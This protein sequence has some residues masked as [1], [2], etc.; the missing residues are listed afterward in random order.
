MVTCSRDHYF[1]ARLHGKHYELKFENTVASNMLMLKDNL[2]FSAIS[3]PRYIAKTLGRHVCIQHILLL[4]I[5]KR[6][7]LDFKAT[8]PKIVHKILTIKLMI[9][10]QY[11]SCEA[12]CKKLKLSKGSCALES[13]KN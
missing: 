9:P 7:P 6:G 4:A 10:I 3:E 1:Q 11:L 13:G 8:F 12:C 5:F 2:D